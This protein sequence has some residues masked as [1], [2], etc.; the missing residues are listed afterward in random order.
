MKKSKKLYRVAF[1]IGIF[2]TPFVIIA[3]RNVWLLLAVF[4]VLLVMV[5]LAWRAMYLEERGQ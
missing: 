3:D 4:A 5:G 2:L 1:L